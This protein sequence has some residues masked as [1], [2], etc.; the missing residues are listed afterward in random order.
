L[1]DFKVANDTHG[2]AEGDRILQVVGEVLKGSIREAD[3]AARLGGD[4][5]A[6][7]LP[8]TDD[9]G[10]RTIIEMVRSKVLHRLK[11]GDTVLTCSIGVV[12]VLDPEASLDGVLAAADELMYKAKREG[13]GGVVFARMGAA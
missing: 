1:D 3:T 8:D 12:T 9:H 5:F 6:L 10:A 11:L 7:L 13:R 4:E 2:H